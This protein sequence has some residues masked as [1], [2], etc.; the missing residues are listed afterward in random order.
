MMDLVRAMPADKYGFAPV[1]AFGVETRQTIGWPRL[2]LTR[3]RSYRVPPVS[4]DLAFKFHKPG[5]R[6]SPAF[7]INIDNNGN[8]QLR[9]LVLSTSTALMPCSRK[10]HFR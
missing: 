4:W 8:S 2:F 9:I 10:K 6:Q 5:R 3:L 1:A 7:A